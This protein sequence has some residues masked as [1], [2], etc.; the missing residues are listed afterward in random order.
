MVLLSVRFLPISS[1]KFWLLVHF[2]ISLASR[3]RW[4]SGRVPGYCGRYGAPYGDRGLCRWMFLV[5]R[6]G[7]RVTEGHHFGYARIYGRYSA[8]PQI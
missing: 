6:G 4:T 5:H 1:S 3:W 2:P 8:K 7:V